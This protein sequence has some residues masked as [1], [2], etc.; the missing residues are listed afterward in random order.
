MVKEETGARENQKRRKQHPARCLPLPNRNN[1]SHWNKCNS[2]NNSSNGS[3]SCSDADAA[4]KV[5]VHRRIIAEEAITGA[6]KLKELVPK[7]KL[8]FPVIKVND[9]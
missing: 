9:F 6:L 3:R 7:D 5:S 1:Y 8:L 4:V 2:N